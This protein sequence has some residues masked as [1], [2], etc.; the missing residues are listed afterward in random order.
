MKTC[1]ICKKSFKTKNELAQHRKDAHAATAKP[2]AVRRAA[3]A[4][5]QQNNGVK[6]TRVGTDLLD[7]VSVAATSGL[8][9]LIYSKLVTPSFCPTTRFGQ[10]SQLWSRW[11]PRNLRLSIR[12]VGSTQYSGSILIGW[13]PETQL[14]LPRG[15]GSLNIVA[16]MK[17]HAYVVPSGT[18]TLNIPC[19]MNKLWYETHSSVMDEMSHGTIVIMVAANLAGFKGAISYII[20]M[21]W[22]VAFEG[23][24]LPVIRANDTLWPDAGWSSLFTTS[25][26]SFDA[27]RLTFKMHSGGSMVSFSAALPGV[28]YKPSNGTRVYYIDEAKTT[29]LCSAFSRVMDYD[30]PGLVLHASAEDAAEYQK[31]GDKTKIIKYTAASAIAAPRIPSFVAMTSVELLDEVLGV[32]VCESDSIPAGEEEYEVVP[33]SQEQDLDDNIARLRE[34]LRGLELLK[35]SS[36]KSSVTLDHGAPPFRGES[37]TN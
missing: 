34:K 29:K 17:P 10:E 35:A 1:P 25:D 5:K 23:P 6:D 24:I 27:E 18:A 26:G 21:N 11:K 7:S 31:G 15:V 20:E 33:S 3:R 28:V 16:G 13:T 2:P 9:D 4:K 22:D 12:G 37:H 19:V 32:R 36:S 8:G 14:N 30:V